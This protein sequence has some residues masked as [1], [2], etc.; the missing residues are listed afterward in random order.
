MSTPSGCTTS[1]VLHI[2]AMPGRE[3]MNG[4]NA[5]FPRMALSLAP[6]AS[7]LLCS[8]FLDDHVSFEL[9]DAWAAQLD[10]VLCTIQRRHVSMGFCVPRGLQN[11]FC[12]RW[13]FGCRWGAT[14]GGTA[15]GSTLGMPCRIHTSNV[16]DSSPPR[17]SSRHHHHHHCHPSTGWSLD[18][19][20]RTLGPDRAAFNVMR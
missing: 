4:G 7:V 17:P 6:A 11:T 12:T 1:C 16:L 3:V 18:G 10:Q 9:Q 2:W 5:G 13:I 14:T 20:P 15:P 8:S 19:H